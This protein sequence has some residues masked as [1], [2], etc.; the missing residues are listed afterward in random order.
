M[1]FAQA[2][3][4]LQRLSGISVPRSTAWEQTARQGTRLC[5]WVERQRE[6]VTPARTRWEDRRYAPRACKSVSIDGGKVHVRHE[7]WKE[8]KLGCISDLETDWSAPEAQTVRLSQTRY[9]AVLGD[10][11]RFAPAMWELAVA[12]GV[13]YAGRS[14]VTSDGAAWIWR[15]SADLFP[16]SVQIVDWYHAR[17]HLAQASQARYP[18]QATC[19]RAWYEQMSHA[20]YR[21]QIRTLIADLLAHDLAD[22]ATYF[23]THQ[24]RMHYQAFREDGYPIGSGAVESGIKQ[25]KHRLTGAGM[26]WSRLGAERMLVIRAAVLSGTLDQLSYAAA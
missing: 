6:G 11:E 23:Q 19:A 15:L 3:Q 7:G 25:F 8:F 5:Q 24:R 13:P 18:S 14:A 26:R 22:H 10:V 20:L 4:V 1:P 16:V 12:C 21:G 17:Q 2:S 9:T